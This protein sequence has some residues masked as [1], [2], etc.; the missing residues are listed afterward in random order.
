MAI[1]VNLAH[2]IDDIGLASGRVYRVGDNGVV[3][4]DNTI[5]A[6]NDDGIVF[7]SLEFEP[8]PGGW[9]KVDP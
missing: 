9:G 1:T 3:I 7:E 4:R 8:A 2:T 5:A 6:F